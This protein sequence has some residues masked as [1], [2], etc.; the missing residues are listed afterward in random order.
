MEWIQKFT[1]KLHTTAQEAG[2][3]LEMLYV[4]KSNLK[5]K[6]RKINNTIVAQGLSHVL[7]DVTLVWYFWVR[8]ESMWHSKIQHGRTVENDPIMQEIVTMM[9]FDASDPG[10]ALISRGSTEMTKAKGEILL[11]CLNDFSEWK[12]DVPQK[13]FVRAIT[14]YLLKIQT[15]HHCNRLILPG[16]TGRIPD[17]VVCAECGR[18][19]EKFIMYRCCND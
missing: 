18:I 1:A 14:D 8:L 11:T 16:T 9:S 7:P 13:G 19:M 6:I 15:P 2:V 5:E 3:P 4:G 17:K 10:W 12:D